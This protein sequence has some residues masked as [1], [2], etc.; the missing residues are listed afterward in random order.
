MKA[1]PVPKDLQDVRSFIGLSSYYQRHIPGYTELAAPQYELA[2]K[3]TEFEWTDWWDEGFESLK[4][5]LILGF[6][7]EEGQ[8]YLDMDASEVGTGAQNGEERV[9]AYASKSLEGRE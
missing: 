5:G 2:R 1:S 4:A 9:I 7:R 3:G 8:W 6:P